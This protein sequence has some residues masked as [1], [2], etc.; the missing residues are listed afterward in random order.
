MTYDTF[1]R[2]DNTKKRIESPAKAISKID[3]RKIY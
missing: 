1:P 3:Y 2:R